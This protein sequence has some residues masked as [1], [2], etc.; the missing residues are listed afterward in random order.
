MRQ[1][2]S[3]YRWVS[4]LLLAA[5]VNGMSGCASKSV[6]KEPAAPAV[7]LGI[8]DM[9]QAIQAHPRFA[10]HDAL[11]QEA[12][13]VQQKLRT[14]RPVQASLTDMEV[15][16]SL[17]QRIDGFQAAQ[18]Q[19]F[20]NKISE[21]QA[22]LNKQLAAKA[23]A[24][25]EQLTTDM[26]AYEQ[27]LDKT[28]QP[29]LFNIQLKIKTVQMEQ[30]EL[31][32]LKKQ[33]EELQS[34]REQKLAVRR[35]ELTAQINAAML[36]EQQRSE[37]ELNEYGRQLHEELAAAAAAKQQEIAMRPPLLNPLPEDATQA[38]LEKRLAE[39]EQQLNVL[40]DIIVQDIRDKTAKIA[41]DKGLQDVIT[42]VLLNVQA[43]DITQEVI[44]A[45]KK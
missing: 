2:N 27:E 6:P 29:Q 13:A 16:A 40:E 35:Q 9:Q 42:K 11:Q 12:Q 26:R 17:D 22:E 38:N 37:A 39:L 3:W 1:K 18:E 41:A 45:C 28:Y 33:M 44:A 21:R 34:E 5:A 25:S 36:P 19:E 32:V 30:S 10:E 24:V 31:D 20:Q 23:A 8:I 15:P 14:Y 43:V 7:K 4:I